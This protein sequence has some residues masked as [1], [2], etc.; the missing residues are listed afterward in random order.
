VKVIQFERHLTGYCDRPTKFQIQMKSQGTDPDII[1][2]ES[3]K[4]EGK[5][6]LDQKAARELAEELLNLVRNYK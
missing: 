6:I 5:L 3:G 2:Y 4:Y 1:V